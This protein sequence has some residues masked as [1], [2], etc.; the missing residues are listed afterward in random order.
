MRSRFAWGL[1]GAL[2]ALAAAT[3]S[4]AGAQAGNQPNLAEM[5]IEELGRI[6]VTSASRGPEPISHASAAIF[7]ITREDMRRAGATSV[8]DALRLAPGLQVARVTAQMPGGIAQHHSGRCAA[9]HQRA[10]GRGLA[11]RGRV[12]AAG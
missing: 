1:A 7:V 4:S 3:P 11:G 5:D 12:A 10:R 6:T 8:P 9:S 2:A